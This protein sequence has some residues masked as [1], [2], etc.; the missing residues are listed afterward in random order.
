MPLET[1]RSFK[2][3]FGAITWP[4]D[5]FVYEAKVS[6]LDPETRRAELYLTSMREN[7]EMVNQ[8]WME[9]DFSKH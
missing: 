6:K 9:C 1:V 7:G 8:A 3:R 4:G 5:R 2:V